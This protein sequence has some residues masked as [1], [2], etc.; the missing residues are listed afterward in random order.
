MN[1]L[2]T[3]PPAAVRQAEDLAGLFNTANAE[4]EAGQR[5]ER[6]S[7]E[8]YRKAG[9]ALLRAKAAAGHGSWLKVLKEKCRIPQQRASEYMRLAEGWDKLPPGG[10][11]A[12]KE[13][14]RYASGEHGMWVSFARSYLECCRDYGRRLL[15]MRAQGRDDGYLWEEWVCADWVNARTGRPPART[16]L[17]TLLYWAEREPSRG[18]AERFLESLG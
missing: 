11:F 5:K 6:E 17:D 8:H 13:A 12:L 2:L 16:F 1:D 9:E 4:H 10:S 15:A 14:L 7:L 3:N 18:D